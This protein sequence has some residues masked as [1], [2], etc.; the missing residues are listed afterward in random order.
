MKKITSRDG[1]PIAVYSAGAGPA[2][3]LVHGSLS[4]HTR[5][6][7]V[8][9]LLSD[10]FTVYTLDRR[11]HGQSGDRAG[12]SLADESDDITAVARSIPG[13]VNLIA[14][15]YGAVCALEAA[16]QIENL[17]KLVLYEPPIQ[18]W[19]RFQPSGAVGR[20]QALVDIGDRAGAV[21]IFA[22][23]VLR[24][25]SLD[26]E[27]FRALPSW[28]TAVATVHTLPRE[29]IAVEEYNFVADRFK[30]FT[31]PTLFLLGSESPPFFAAVIEA[32]N[33]ALSHSHIVVLPGQRHAAM[34]SAPQ[35]FVN[36]VVRFLLSS[37]KD[38]SQ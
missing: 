11:G 13:P 29:M 37:A 3:L 23:E 6:E 24:M 8:S 4:D 26:L 7:S 15:S 1:T 31:V 27:R 35:L 25:K 20:I 2:L 36:E 28:Q 10:I 12:Y 17:H 22:S 5:W 9:A 34:D 38:S 33:D 14:H 19:I 30:D 32:L 21:M 18:T 16:W